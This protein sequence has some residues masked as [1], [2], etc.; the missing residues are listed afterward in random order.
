[1]LSDEE[2]LEMKPLSVLVSP[3]SILFSSS[4][5]I[6]SGLGFAF[7]SS[8]TSNTSATGNESAFPFPDISLPYVLDL[9]GP[10]NCSATEPWAAVTGCP[11]MTGPLSSATLGFA[12]V[13]GSAALSSK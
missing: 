9:D 7:G 5:C 6:F 11:G 8:L 12:K 3:L 13:E 4:I 2:G 1:M 10:L